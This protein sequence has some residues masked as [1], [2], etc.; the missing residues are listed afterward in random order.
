MSLFACLFACLFV[1]LFAVCV[2]FVCSWVDCTTFEG[3]FIVLASAPHLARILVPELGM[4]HV[5]VAAWA[6]GTV[7][8]YT[9]N[10]MWHAVDIRVDTQ[11]SGMNR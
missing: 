6:A 8:V 2:W 5:Y 3:A 10:T 9:C 1:C 11:A 4:D 7:C